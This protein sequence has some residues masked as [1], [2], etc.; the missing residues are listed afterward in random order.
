MLF[1]DAQQDKKKLKASGSK[2]ERKN[3]KPFFKLVIE[4]IVKPDSEI[5][6]AGQKNSEN[7]SVICIQFSNNQCR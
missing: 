2:R 3:L 1:V 5:L 7:R 4:I 6:H